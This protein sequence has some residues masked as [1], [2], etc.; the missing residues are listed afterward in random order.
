VQFILAPVITK[1]GYK[2]ITY[3]KN[4][5]TLHQVIGPDTFYAFSLHST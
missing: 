1:K 2:V 4:V 5:E 3:S